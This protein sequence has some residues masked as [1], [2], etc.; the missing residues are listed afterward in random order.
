MSNFTA[1]TRIR[2]ETTYHRAEWID[3]HYDHKAYGVKF[4]EGPHEGEIHPARNCAIAK[5]D[6]YLLGEKNAS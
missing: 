5:D 3:N 4:L 1:R 2:G 6:N